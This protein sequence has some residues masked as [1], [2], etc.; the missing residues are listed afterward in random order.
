MNPVRSQPVHAARRPP[1]I[2]ASS[3]APRQ[4]LEPASCPSTSHG[5]EPARQ[6]ARLISELRDAIAHDTLGFDAQPVVDLRDD[7]IDHHELRPLW[8]H[9][10][11]GKLPADT[12]AV[13]AEDTGLMPALGERTFHQ[14]LSRLQRG[15]V[16]SAAPSAGPPRLALRVSPLLLLA[17]ANPVGPWLSRLD[18]MGL[19][20]EQLMLTV[21]EPTLA[22]QADALRPVLNRLH[23]AGLPFAFRHSG[24]GGTLVHLR[25]FGA[26]LLKFDREM[27]RDIEHDARALALCE[28]LVERA[29]KLDLQVVAE[30]IETVTQ[31]VVLEAIG[32]DFGQGRLFA[33]CST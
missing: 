6:R 27:L 31:R 4:D 12:L 11:C 1:E 17:D 2:V 3:R 21:D 23:E 26:R 32:C 28:R 25:G 7:R 16:R 15:Q 14:A 9:P 30:G 13:L 18:A 24:G 29:H 33:A 20:R 22:S 10:G 19:C 8:D 5:R